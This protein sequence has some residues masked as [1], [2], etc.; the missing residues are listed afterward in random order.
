MER[1]RILKHELAWEQA[2]LDEAIA[3]K[4]ANDVLRRHR[5]NIESLHRE[6]SNVQ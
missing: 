1:R 4:D 6:I 2:A 5:E 3:N